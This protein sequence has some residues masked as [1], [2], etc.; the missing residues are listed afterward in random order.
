MAPKYTNAENQARHRAKL[1]EQM[2][3]EAFK[4]QEAKRKREQREKKKAINKEL[5]PEQLSKPLEQLKQ[6][7]PVKKRVIPILKTKLSDA[8]IKLYS[9][10]IKSFYKHYTNK[11]L[12]LENDNID[13]LNVIQNM[14]YRYKNIK[15]DFKF[16]NDKNTFNDIINTYKSKIGYL[17]SIMSRVYGL[18]SIVNKLYP[19]MKGNQ[20]EYENDRAN[21][22][23]PDNVINTISFDTQDV[24]NKVENA[25]LDRTEK[26]MAY[27]A[28]LLPTKRFN[29]YRL[30]KISKIKPNDTFNK[31]FNYYFN[32]TIYIFNTK[33]K[34]YNEIN[35]PDEVFKLIDNN[36]E[37]M[38]G[39]L[40]NQNTFTQ[41][42]PNIM[43]KI[44]GMAI[45]NTLMRRLYSSYLRSLNLN[46][47]D[48]EKEA[49]KMGHS[50][51]QNLKYSYVKK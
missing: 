11:D 50:L 32:G 7:K 14:P 19:Y 17:Y 23:I 45:N 16:L 27:L 15:S 44:Y 30:V 39:K 10:F 29:E 20:K 5:K 13:I 25:D 2:G 35:I 21:R 37:F 43:F 24:I 6:L 1:I 22:L 3:E 49:N 26:I 48:Y 18:T 40:Y 9:S 33:N 12:S 34:V 46:G 51:S 28:L 42:L 38:M 31:S 4:A 8:T 47:N 36:D 41:K